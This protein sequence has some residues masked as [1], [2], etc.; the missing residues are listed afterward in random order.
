[1]RNRKAHL[2]GFFHEYHKYSKEFI[3]LSLKSLALQLVILT[4]LGVF[5]SE[6]VCAEENSG[7]QQQMKPVPCKPTKELMAEVQTKYG[8][9]P[10]WFGEDDESHY[11]VM[12][13]RKTRT[14]TWIQYNDELACV[15]GFGQNVQ[16]DHT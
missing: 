2:L 7:M 3:M 5:I 6:Y 10:D 14:W 13:N 12:L 4:I 1:M 15:L 16:K 8:E 11:V 9:E